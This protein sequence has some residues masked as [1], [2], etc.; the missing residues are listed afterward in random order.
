[1]TIG[2][3]VPT[4]TSA[5]RTAPSCPEPSVVPSS[6][7]DGR[8]GL[9]SQAPLVVLATVGMGTLSLAVSF[10]D[11]EGKWTHRIARR[12]AKMLLGIGGVKVRVRGLEHIRAPGPYVF[13]G[14]HQS[15]M[16]TPVVLAHVPLR[17]L[18]LVSA[19]YVKIP[20]WART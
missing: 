15:L 13:V 11:R 4:L 10:L 18:F 7:A 9:L 16:D 3:P 6:K 2:A 20:S 12:W 1:M 17:F 14:N 8:L 19:K 5:F